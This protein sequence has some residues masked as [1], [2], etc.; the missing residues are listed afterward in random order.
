MHSP[1]PIILFASNHKIPVICGTSFF[2]PRKGRTWFKQRI[3]EERQ[4]FAEIFRCRASLGCDFGFK[5]WF[6]GT[7]MTSVINGFQV[8]A[9]YFGINL[10]GGKAGMA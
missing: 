9:A 2:V 10:G 4:D 8:T 5:K 6:L 3:L 1:I 7:G